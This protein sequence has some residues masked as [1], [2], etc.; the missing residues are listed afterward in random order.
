MTPQELNLDCEAL[1]E[2]REGLNMGLRAV[3][4]K[5]MKRGLQSGTVSAK[6]EITIHEVTTSDGEIVRMIALEPKVDMK[7]GSK[8]KFDLSKQD[9]MLIKTDGD[10]NPIIGTSQISIDDLIRERER[11][12]A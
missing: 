3:A 8:A 4:L 9:G 11:A 10:G 12:G 7:I 5:I 1:A 2:F 6:V